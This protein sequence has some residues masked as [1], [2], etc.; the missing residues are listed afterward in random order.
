MHQIYTKHSRT[1]SDSC[2]GLLHSTFSPAV[3]ITLTNLTFYIPAL[4]NA[5][6]RTETSIAILFIYLGNKE[7]AFFVKTCCIKVSVF[8]KMSYFVIFCLNN[9]FF[10]NRRLKFEYRPWIGKVK[11][12]PAKILIF[13]HGKWWAEVL[14]V[15]SV[16]SI[17]MQNTCHLYKW[18]MLFIPREYCFPTRVQ[19]SIVRGSARNLEINNFDIR[20]WQYALFIVNDLLLQNWFRLET[21]Q[22]A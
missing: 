6:A 9:M 7:I 18:K 10:V 16:P 13:L 14:N 19:H 20:R 3:L 15:W 4:P 12:G 21:E 1:F 11:K 2:Y 22:T 5:S 8:H 17:R